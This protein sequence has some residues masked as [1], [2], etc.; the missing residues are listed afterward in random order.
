MRKLDLCKSTKIKE[1]LFLNY[2]RQHVTDDITNEI[3]NLSDAPSYPY[4]QDV[5]W[6]HVKKLVGYQYY[7]NY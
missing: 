1:K 7:I 4:L 2:L 5:D 3:E 6:D